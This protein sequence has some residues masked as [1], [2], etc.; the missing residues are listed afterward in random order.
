[1][2]VSTDSHCNAVEAAKH[3]TVK[4]KDVKPA[5]VHMKDA[6]AKESFAPCAVPDVVT[7]DPDGKK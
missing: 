5:I 4:Y 1:M 3:V 6:I 2:F 7:G